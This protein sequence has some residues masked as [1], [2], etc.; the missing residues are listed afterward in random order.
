MI[1]LLILKKKRR[2]YQIRGERGRR[3]VSK[4]HFIP[5]ITTG[6][7][8]RRAREGVE[9]IVKTLIGGKETNGTEARGSYIKWVTKHLFG[10]TGAN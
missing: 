1:L 5:A 9:S 8:R 3:Q 7:R 2:N 4:A 6:T 10:H